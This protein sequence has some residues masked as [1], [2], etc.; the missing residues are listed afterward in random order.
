MQQKNRQTQLPNPIIDRMMSIAWVCMGISAVAHGL[1]NTGISGFMGWVAFV[2]ACLLFYS[3]S[4]SGFSQ[5]RERLLK[6]RTSFIGQIL[7]VVIV[8]AQFAATA[9]V[10]DAR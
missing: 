10:W 2:S 1:G 6:Q 9:G 8:V 5:G 7:L 4:I 3:N